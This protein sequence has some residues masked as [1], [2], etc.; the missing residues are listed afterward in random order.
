MLC[1][2]GVWHLLNV[3]I[4][5]ASHVETRWT[6]SWRGTVPGLCHGYLGNYVT[7]CWPAGK[8]KLGARLEE[9]RERCWRKSPNVGIATARVVSVS[10]NGIH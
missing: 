2:V 10:A 3:C 9:T 4:H 6:S 1:D 5:S 8:I 7:S